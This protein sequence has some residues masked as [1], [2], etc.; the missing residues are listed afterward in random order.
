MGIAN[1]PNLGSLAPVRPRRSPLRALLAVG[2]LLL[3]A[4]LF[5][6]SVALYLPATAPRPDLVLLVAL[7]WGF[8]RGSGEG[9]LAA[10]V[11][12]LLLDCMGSTPFGLQVLAFGL[13]V[14]VVS[15]DGRFSTSAARRSV[16]AAVAAAIV[17]L[18]ILAVLQMRGW[19]PLWPVVLVR[20]TL[21]ALVADAALLPVVYALLRRLPEPAADPLLGGD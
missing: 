9:F 8:L 15:G 20:G 17:H 14:L 5:Q 11:G 1:I 4:A 2:L 7:A 10:M 13:A 6:T 16:G 3:V 12:A 21:P 18:L 19:E